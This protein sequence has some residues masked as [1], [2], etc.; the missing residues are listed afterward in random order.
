MNIGRSELTAMRTKIVNLERS[1]IE[2]Q[3]LE[4]A[5]LWFIECEEAMFTVI[6]DERCQ[7]DD[8]WFEI[9]DS[10]AAALA[11]VSTLVGIKNANRTQ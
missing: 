7:S 6:N 11:E 3:A 4:Q 5:V 9:L 1:N 10:R 2:K 8:N